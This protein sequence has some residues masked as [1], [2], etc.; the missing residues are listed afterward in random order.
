MENRLV[1]STGVGVERGVVIYAKNNMETQT[2]L[3][4]LTSLVA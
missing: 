2:T 4:K 3:C 1:D